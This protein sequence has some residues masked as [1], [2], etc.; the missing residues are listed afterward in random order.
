MP[1]PPG[2][3]KFLSTCRPVIMYVNCTLLMPIRMRDPGLYPLEVSEGEPANVSPASLVQRTFTA[4]SAHP[5]G[6]RRITLELLSRKIEKIDPFV[7]KKNGAKPLLQRQAPFSSAPFKQKMEL[8][9]WIFVPAKGSFAGSFW[10]C[11]RP[12]GMASEAHSLVIPL[13]RIM[14]T[15]SRM[16]STT[17]ST[18]ESFLTCWLKSW[19]FCARISSCW[20]YRRAQSELSA[21]MIP[22]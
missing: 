6:E 8:N 1:P 7:L 18:R 5:S 14:V 2:S 9:H 13:R 22:S 20:S 3:S 4:D 10:G 11:S 17:C 15:P 12:R 19:S 21:R 16:V